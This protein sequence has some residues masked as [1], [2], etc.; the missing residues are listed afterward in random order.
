MHRPSFK[1]GNR[2][3]QQLATMALLA[4]LL[5][6]PVTA[7]EQDFSQP[8][9]IDSQKQHIDLKNNLATYTTNVIIKQGSLSINADEI[10]AFRRDQKGSELFIA[11]GDPARYSQTLEDGKPIS[12]QADTIRY[13]ARSRTL[14]L[15]GN[16][17]LTQNDSL[18]RG[19]IIR[20][21]LIKQELE[22]EGDTKSIITPDEKPADEGSQP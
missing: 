6:L 14:V 9:A 16:A 17:R 18:V 8:I 21:D 5:A 13:D 19:R 15:E 11:T 22:A 1:T 4:S 20:Y 12:A 7:S 10:K 3:N 2:I